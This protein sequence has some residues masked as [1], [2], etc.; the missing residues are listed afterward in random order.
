MLSFKNVVGVS[1][2]GTATG[3][4]DESE[5]PNDNY[6]DHYLYPEDTKSESSYPVVDASGDLRRGNVDAAW[7]LGAR[8]GVDEDE[9][10]RKLKKL[11][12]EFEN[13]PIPEDEYMTIKIDERFR[14]HCPRPD[15]VL[16]FS[17]F[18][19]RLGVG[20][21]EYGVRENRGQD[22]TLDSVDV[23]F[24]AMEP[25]PPERRNGVRITPD[26]LRD[27]ASKEYDPSPPHLKDHNSD[28][29][30]SK[31]G[32]VEDVWF[33]E[34]SE[35]LMLMTRT[36]NIEG[37]DNHQEA[38]A[39]YTHDPPSIRDGSL[40]FGKN[41][42]AARND[43]GEPELVEGK[44][45]EFSTVNFPGGYDE[46]GV[47]AA[48][49]EAIT[50]GDADPTFEGHMGEVD[51]EER[52][53]VYEKW[54]ELVNL[55]D[56]QMTMWDDHP[57]SD[58]GL[59]ESEQVRD[60]TQMLIGQPMMDW[61]PNEVRIA[62]KAIAYMLDATQDMPDR[63][64][65][66]GPGSCPSRWW[67][68]LLN[69]GH[70]PV[71]EMPTGNPKFSSEK[72]SFSEHGM[73]YG[74][75][76]G[77]WVE[78][79]WQGGEVYMKV[80]E[81]TKDSFTVDGNTIS[82]DDGEPVYK[83]EEY[84]TD[85]GEFTGQMV[86]APQSGVNSWS[87][88][89]N[90]SETAA[91]LAMTFE[92]RGEELDEVYSDWSDAVNMTASQLERWGEH[93]CANEG[94]QKPQTVRDRNMR[95]LETDKADW[96]SDDISDAK[97][98]ISFI[99]RMSADNNKPEDPKGGNVGT[100]PSE[101]AISLLNWAYNPFDTMPD[102][103]PDPD[104]EENAIAVN[105][106]KFDDGDNSS[107][108]PENLATD[109]HTIEF[110]STMELNF[111]RVTHEDN[112]GDFSEDEL[113]ELIREYEDAQDANVAEF[114]SVAETLDGVDA[115]NISEFESARATLIEN[116]TDAPRFSEIPISEAGLEE[117]TFGEL[118]DWL[119]FVSEKGANSDD[120]G[121]FDDYGNKAPV[122]DDEGASDFAEETLSG[123]QGLSL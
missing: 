3:K 85:A 57:C 86:A 48:F 81:R 100:C 45:R 73:S 23:I 118:Q 115:S 92:E 74:F 101:W 2:S 52:S 5:I 90:M 109:A 43:D 10:T 89:Q 72:V 16:D 113:R 53:R 39:R 24:A 119:E 80:R 83:G 110:N 6:R 103:D 51:P 106:L 71:D 108:E 117:A 79:D 67:I 82:G 7:G 111:T 58:H 55:T 69:H 76:V 18:E 87:G 123:M 22:G 96:D 112:L 9:H 19:D 116:I 97:R 91:H 34:H 62:N 41:Y 25:G 102:G 60:N 13:N 27:V 40:G 26:F 107:A 28:D 8:G 64:D 121:E 36:P 38:I 98:T 12:K 104:A 99:N 78:R 35:K 44:F 49:A 31:I 93:P 122:N 29:T 66:G 11:G 50:E 120:G 77:D 15:D 88:P 42:E 1:F 94:S 68:T 84:D 17:R 75:S 114:E 61:G 20:F 59:M 33:D 37:S 65:E 46:G 47:N 105:V 4:L 21:N 70:N 56:E 63:P 95:L 54:N 30:F 14:F 32:T